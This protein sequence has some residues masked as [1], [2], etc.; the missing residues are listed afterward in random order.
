MWRWEWALSFDECHIGCAPFFCVCFLSHTF[1]S[2]SLSL[3][4]CFSVVYCWALAQCISYGNIFVANC[5]H[6][7]MSHSLEI[8]LW[9]TQ[10]LDHLNGPANRIIQI[11]NFPTDLLL[12]S[13]C[14]HTHTRPQHHQTVAETFSL[15]NKSQMLT[16]THNKKNEKKIE[17]FS[18]VRW[19]R[20]IIDE[21]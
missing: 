16:H 10:L 6:I 8:A 4:P 13:K 18:I 11:T 15:Q 2:L 9:R 3:V 21:P 19:I 20:R 14:Q 5:C 17:S 7:Q 12:S 1:F